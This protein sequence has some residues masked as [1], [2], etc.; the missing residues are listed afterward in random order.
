MK[1]TAMFLK[2][3]L[4]SFLLILLCACGAYQKPASTYYERPAPIGYSPEDQMRSAPSKSMAYPEQAPAAP[5]LLGGQSHLKNQNQVQAQDRESQDHKAQPPKKVVYQGNITLR[6][7]QLRETLDSAVKEAEKV[8]GFVESM[9]SR[10]VILRVPVQHFDAT[11]QK[12]ISIGLVVS[13]S[14]DAIDISAQY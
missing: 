13:K 14:I 1:N 3:V 9:G 10:F 11:F 7:K 5:S 4:V 8:G 12:L 6:V 2:L